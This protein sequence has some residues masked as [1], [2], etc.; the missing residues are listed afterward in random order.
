MLTSGEAGTQ[1]LNLWRTS[2]RCDI[3]ILFCEYVF[4][5]LVYHFSFLIIFIYFILIIS[6]TDKI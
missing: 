1:C 2:M 4:L 3:L 6:E 5:I